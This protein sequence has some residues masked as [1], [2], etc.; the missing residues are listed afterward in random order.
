MQSLSQR[1]KVI[2]SF[3]P[4]GKS[5][6]DVGTDHGYLP[7]AL[8]LGGKCKKVTATDI[9]EKPLD[10]A[11]NNLKRLGVKDVNLILCDGLED[12]DKNDAETVIIAGMGGDVIS[13]IIENC[14]FKEAPLFILQPMTAA[15]TLRDY[16]A[17]NGFDV[18]K[19]TALSENRKIYSVMTARF[20]GKCR[21]L[22]PSQRRIGKLHPV[23]EENIKYIK[24]QQ[25]IA[26]RCVKNLKNI[27]KKAELYEE[28][29]Q[30]AEELRLVLEG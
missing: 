29:L 15:D 11:R 24:K 14:P 30:I 7:A 6:C 2:A 8:S 12:V 21:K 23:S 13:K 4:Q 17:Q 3:I 28:S 1:L 25:I 5:V 9:R 10:N 20:D 27:P 19:E 18:L 26:E 22:S 16:L